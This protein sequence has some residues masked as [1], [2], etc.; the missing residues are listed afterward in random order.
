MNTQQPYKIILVDDHV[1]LRDALAS[2]INSF[3]GF[4]V[5]DVAANGKDLIIAIENGNVPNLVVLDLNMPGMDG[6]ET[7][8]W[9]HKTLPDIKILIL[10]MFDSEIALIRL[11]Q[12]GVRGFL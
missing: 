3:D 7:T 12:E 9:L 6:Y 11:L 10:T 8:K 5:I 1:L 4:N 2:L